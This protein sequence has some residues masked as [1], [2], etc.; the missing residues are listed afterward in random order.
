MK[1]KN[2]KLGF[3][4]EWVEAFSA[5]RHVG[6]TDDGKRVE[7]D[8]TP[9]YLNALARNYD[10]ALHEA[11]A[12]I[13]HPADDLPA[14]GWISDVR[15]NGDKLELQFADTQPEFE[16]MVRNNLFKKRS[17]KLY[18]DAAKAPGGV[19]PNIRHCAFLGA[20][21]PAIKNLKNMQQPHFSDDE[22][23]SIAFDYEGD[24]HFS[25]GEHMTDAEK[26]AAQE[27]AKKSVGDSV[28][29]YFKELFGGSKDKPE[30]AS[31]SEADAQS[32]V[33]KAVKAAELKFS[34]T[35]KERDTK[36]EEL[37]KKVNAHGDSSHRAEIL[38]FCESNL[39]T[40]LP[41]FKGMGLVEF[42]ESLAVDDA[43]V[44]VISF[45]ED[46]KQQK[47]EF[48]RLDWFKT[49]MKSLPPFIQFGESFGTL[50]VTGDGSQI[51]DSKQ[52][53]TL[54]DSMGVKKPEAAA[55]K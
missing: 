36:I 25:E 41:A 18:A 21:P 34:E 16:R 29:E 15:V 19:A 10:V 40:V 22:G 28:R 27:E 12:T 51:V 44:T 30:T 49:F 11:P 2:K 35:L 47:N 13:G 24:I 38:Q 46:G 4:G 54:R 39:Q 33:D 32:I 55:A 26:K 7:L 1:A 53:D 31:F 8:V 52:V 5:G 43:K 45:A 42:M 6:F 48:S 20:E 23:E 3:D 50:K 17:L 37:T 14:Y 9:E